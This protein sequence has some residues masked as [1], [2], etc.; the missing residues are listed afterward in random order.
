MARIDRARSA[1]GTRRVA[2]KI[3]GRIE[4]RRAGVSDSRLRTSSGA[5]VGLDQ[6]VA[7]SI[8]VCQGVRGHGI[9]CG[10]GKRSRTRGFVGVVAAVTRCALVARGTAIVVTADQFGGVDSVRVVLAGSKPGQQQ[11]R[12]CGKNVPT[13]HSLEPSLHDG[14]ASARQ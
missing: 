12:S 7:G 2:G 11:G 10:V 9:R 4:A 5:E 3:K 14:A 8:Q 1:A 6:D 13:V